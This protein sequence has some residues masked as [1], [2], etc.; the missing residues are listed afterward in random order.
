M[1]LALFQFSVEAGGEREQKR[2]ERAERIGRKKSETGN[3]P[4][5]GL[6]VAVAVAEMR[7]KTMAP[8]DNA[9]EAAS[10][11]RR[12]ASAGQAS[13]L[14][15]RRQQ[16][17]PLGGGG[18]PSERQ[19]SLMDSLARCL[20]VGQ[21]RS[22]LVIII[23]SARPDWTRVFGR[24]AKS[25]ARAQEHFLRLGSSFSWTIMCERKQ[26]LAAQ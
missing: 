10:H 6:A 13:W 3:G 16:L 9:D 21:V 19:A 1:P 25:F 7:R 26:T 23:C 12:P 2:R 20:R 14:S 8:R 5:K 18:G 24:E 22:A 15:T 17:S 11:H 4:D